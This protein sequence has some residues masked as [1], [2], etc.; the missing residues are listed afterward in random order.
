M[1]NSEVITYT[2]TNACRGGYIKHHFLLTLLVL[3]GLHLQAQ[4]NT[5]HS[6]S[7]TFYTSDDSLQR[8][9][10][11][12][13]EKAR[14]NIQDWKKYKVLVEGAGYDGVWLET[15][16][17]GGVMYAKRDIGIAKDNIRIFLDYQR[18]DGR[19]RSV[20]GHS[21]TTMVAYDSSLSGF[22][23]PMPALELFF[24]LDKD[25]QLLGQLYRSLEKFDSYLWKTRDSD[26]NGC[27]ETWCVWDTGEDN[28]TRFGRSPLDWPFD[29]PPTEERLKSETNYAHERNVDMTLA[30]PV[31]IESMDI[32]SYSYTCR[33]FLSLAAG[34]LGNGKEGY[35]RDQANSVRGKIK[36]YL[37]DKN[38][39]ACFD[40]DKSNLRMNIL[41][42][43]NLRCMYYGSFD[44]Q[45]ADEFIKYHLLNPSEFWTKMPLPS[46]AANDPMFRNISG[47]NWSGQPQG[48][49][50]QRSI[51]ALENYGHYAELTMIGKIFLKAISDS[52]KFTQQFDPFTGTINNTSDGYGPSILSS[53]EFISRLYGIHISRDKI[54][55][56]CL[57]NNHDYRYTQKWGDRIFKMETD[58]N[59]VNSYINGNKV[60]SFTKGIRVV[61]DL[62]GEIIEV[63]GITP[64]QKNIKVDIIKNGKTYSLVIHP[65]NIFHYDGSFKKARSADFYTIV[66]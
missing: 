54:N 39:H 33:D 2:S 20:I 28:S 27:L 36:D 15:Q 51:R 53:L 43:N 24:W 10:D 62:R 4:V 9:F 35:W 11:K 18:E 40:R 17:M 12:A 61:S 56:S 26:G 5:D 41:L 38:K 45:M 42:H 1:T 48:L 65:N 58:G 25:N 50:F 22:C 7:V 23:L 44:Q 32:M 64:S 60:F 21:D 16:P 46:I 59:Q 37:W 8:V 34:I 55:W 57:D 47:N 31:P 3:A 13:E 19:F 49:T 30:L 66:K 29:Y 63:I 6:T 14:W 52:L